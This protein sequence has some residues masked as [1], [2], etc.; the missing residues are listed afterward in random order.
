MS[1]PV[2]LS[3]HQHLVSSLLINWLTHSFI[4]AVLISVVI[5]YCDFTFIFL[6]SNYIEYPL[7]CLFAIY[8]ALVKCLFMYFPIFQL[9][10]LLF[11]IQFWEFLCYLDPCLSTLW[12]T[13]CSIM[14]LIFHPFHRELCG[15]FKFYNVQ[16]TT[17]LFIFV[18]F[19]CLS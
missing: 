17:F 1:S 18:S 2:S 13:I 14:H 19:C 6:M 10:S 9:D 12:Q 3:S 11:T 5:F 16:V 15:V 4:Q 8:I 7:M